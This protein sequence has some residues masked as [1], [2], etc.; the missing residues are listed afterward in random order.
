MML[1]IQYMSF[2]MI[3]F[4]LSFVYLAICFWEYM[5]ATQVM[6]CYVICYVVS[7]PR[8]FAAIVTH[9]CFAQ[10]ILDKQKASTPRSLVELMLPD[11]GQDF[12]HWQ[13]RWDRERRHQPSQHEALWAH[14][15]T[16]RNILLYIIL[17]IEVY[18]YIYIQ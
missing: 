5:E 10:D 14:R 17:Y 2:F 16:Y 13:G 11:N 7:I 6:L 3:P 8:S 15:H 1:E 18:E 12:N 4:L 9:L